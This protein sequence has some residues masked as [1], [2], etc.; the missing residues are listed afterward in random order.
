MAE[1][2]KVMLPLPPLT[3]G[4]APRILELVREVWREA[5]RLDTPIGQLPQ[6]PGLPVDQERVELFAAQARRH[7]DTPATSRD[8]KRAVGVLQGAFKWPGEDVITNKVVYLTMMYETLKSKGFASAVI[9]QAIRAA[10]P[11]YNWMPSVKELVEECR[12]V[13]RDIEAGLLYLEAPA[14]QRFPISYNL[15]MG[16]ISR[17]E[18]AAQLRRERRLRELSQPSQKGGQIDTERGSN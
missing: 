3:L 10:I 8:I 15:K 13:R 1:N 6:L 16:L 4:E 9:E 14:E 5:G 18:A 7:F 11:N 12:S 17:D 2:Q